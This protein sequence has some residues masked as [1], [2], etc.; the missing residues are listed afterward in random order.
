MGLFIVILSHAVWGEDFYVAQTAQGTNSGTNAANAHAV[1]W[2][3]TNGN[4]GVVTGKIG[5]GDIVHLCGT[6]TTQF[7]IQSSGTSGNSITVRWE[8]GAKLSVPYCVSSGGSLPSGGIDFQGNS[9]ITLDGGTPC[10][11]GTTCAA[12]DAGTGI[13]EA[14]AN[15][16]G[17]ANH[18]DGSALAMSNA[19]GVE[20]K[21]LIIRN[22]YQFTNSSDTYGGQTYAIN[23]Y[24]G[25]CHSN[26][27]HDCTI[28][29]A[30]AGL[31]GT[32]DQDNDLSFY[33][34][35]IYN[36]NWGFY[37][38]TSLGHSQSNISIHDN[39][40][41]SV[42]K[43]DQINNNN[44]HDRLFLCTGGNGYAG[45]FNGV[46]IYNNLF[47]G[48][49][50][51][52]STGMIYFG[53]GSQKN[54]YVYNNVF[55]DSK[56]VN[57]MNAL[58]E[59]T[60]GDSVTAWVY[61]NTLIGAG[62]G[63]EQ[64]C[65]Q[66]QGTA[67]FENNIATGCA[68]LVQAKSG[69]VFSSINNNTYGNANAAQI[70]QSASGYTNYASLAAWRTFT[71][72]EAAS[73]Y[74]SG[75]VSLNSDGILKNGSP[76]IA[77]GANLTSLGIPS[78]NKDKAGIAR[79]SSGAWD[80]GAYQYTTTQIQN[81]K[82]KIQNYSTLPQLI[83]PNPIKVALLKQYLQKNDNLSLYDLAGNPVKK[84]SLKSEGVYLVQEN[85][86]QITQKVAII[87]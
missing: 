36:V 28:H 55:D 16:S 40:F 46:Y 84:E 32:C 10:G 73:T 14:I 83:S 41:G 18:Q 8:P 61:N 13:I 7:A 74:T 63:I 49:S 35:N 72:G 51:Y 50:G 43:W 85:T 9:Y 76:A 86:S 44:H 22:I 81:P 87:K 68:T 29:D 47:N 11:T 66:L 4:W 27:V 3:N 30:F 42:S 5:P 78:L 82:S 2:L 79:P 56:G 26:S 39:N 58:L 37:H 25:T 77:A 52:S 19:V 67:V 71:G 6:I 53:G 48:T 24:G 15:G 69:L 80:T 75:G 65:V 1:A 20:V 12:N 70:F 64:V 33:N 23:L 45:S 38:G 60:G 21:N 62:I 31:L 57:T 17:L 59:L 54:T 34:N